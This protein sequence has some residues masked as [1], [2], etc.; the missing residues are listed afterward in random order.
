MTLGTFGIAFFAADPEIEDGLKEI[1]LIALPTRVLIGVD[2]AEV[3][4]F[5][6]LFPSRTGSVEGIGFPSLVCNFKT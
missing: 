3:L 6:L 5:N 4:E 2:P 1:V